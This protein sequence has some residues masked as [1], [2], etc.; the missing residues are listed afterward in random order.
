MTYDLKGTKHNI[1]QDEFNKF[2]ALIGNL[3]KNM[4]R[5]I[6]LFKKETN[7]ESK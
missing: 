6:K 5:T 1:T 2:R 4:V 7:I 3:D